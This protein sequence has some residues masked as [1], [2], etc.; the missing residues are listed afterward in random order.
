MQEGAT[1]FLE[2]V[3]PGGV[4]DDQRLLVWTLQDKASHWLASTAFDVSSVEGKDVYVGAGL[5]PPGLRRTQRATNAG[6]TAVTGIPGLWVDLDF[7]DGDAHKKQNLPTQAEAL[8]F[9]ADFERATTP[10]TVIVNSGHGYQLWWLF[11]EPWLFADQAARERASSLQRWWVYTIRDAARA[12][13]WDVDATIDLAR[14]MRLP[15]TVNHKSEPVPVTILRATESRRTVAQWLDVMDAAPPLA[16]AVSRAPARPRRARTPGEPP[17]PAEGA[18]RLSAEATPP[19]DKWQA[20]RESDPRVEKTWR[21]QRKDLKDQSPSSYD[22]ALASFTVAVGWTDQEITDLLIAARRHHGDDLKIDRAD[23]YPRTILRAR[24]TVD[25][26]HLDDAID[27]PAGTPAEALARL[28]R[29]FGVAINR[30]VKYA[31]DPPTYVLELST[32]IITLG[33]VEAI[34]T[35]RVFRA[36]VAAAVDVVIPK[37]S[38]GLWDKRA[39]A[40]LSAMTEES[41][42]P[43]ASPAGMAAAW[44]DEYVRA[45][46]PSEDAGAALTGRP[47]MKD[48]LLHIT[49][50]SLAY[51][52]RTAQGER[53]TQRDLAL[54]LRMAGFEQHTQWV[55]DNDS[56]KETTRSL[57]RERESGGEQV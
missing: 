25:T 51:W 8:E 26:S 40:M 30:I 35:Q 48:G 17:A 5:G 49:L 11:A 9:I 16:E 15:G 14:V 46:R 19:F 50:R 22:M 28:S 24:N 42:G 57:W 45:N 18:L 29:V 6:A 27:E 38:E 20:L 21:R 36:K 52:L 31:G 7:A 41:L 4:P 39:Q 3:W 23:Y 37:C 55:K 2:I 33:G 54:H 34:L 10:A 56:G 44:V 53:V 12:R 1:R 43:E 32:G 47:F 13:G